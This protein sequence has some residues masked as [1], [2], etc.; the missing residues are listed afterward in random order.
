MVT[1]MSVSVVLIGLTLILV[2][3]LFVVPWLR[4]R[5][6]APLSDGTATAAASL[7]AG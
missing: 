6:I 4:Q 1:F 7:F 2:L 5:T 3:S